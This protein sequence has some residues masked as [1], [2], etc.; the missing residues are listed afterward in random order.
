MARAVP[1][2]KLTTVQR[3]P[4]VRRVA[5]AYSGGLD[6]SLCVALLR[7][8]YGVEEVVPITVDVGQG[9]D[10]LDAAA[11]T[12]AVLGI[13]PRV[14]DARE[15]FARDWLAPAI[16]ANADYL[17]YPVATAMT[18]QLIARLVAEQAVALGCDGLAEGSSGK[19]NDQYRMHNVFTLFAPGLPILVPVRDLDLTRTEE[20]ALCAHFGI[21]VDE[22]IPGGDDKTL[23]CR[24][25]ASGGLG[26]DTPI[27]DA[28]WRWY[29]PPERAPDRP[30]TVTLTFTGGI[31]VAL[32]GTPMALA[33]L[34]DAL[35]VLAG[36]YGIGR[37]DIL[38]DGIMGLKS[39]EVYEAPAATVV[40]RAHRDLEQLTLTKEEVQFK[41][42][43]D[44]AWAALVYHGDWFHPLRA[45]LDAFIGRSQEVVEGEVSLRLYKGS[46]EVV[47]RASRQSLFAPE[48]RSIATGG[49][50]QRLCGPAAQIRGL[51]YQVLAL[52]RAR[53]KA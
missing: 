29:V 24:S 4:R 16:R 30:A 33:D 27:P 3:A 13:T 28:V 50:D 43:I 11:R 46:M 9:A 36:G 2:E 39:R 6:S 53:A 35:N 12:A 23:W 5:L 52:R 37:I 41:R 1:L 22:P 40:L 44:Q 42:G 20:R 15:E 21:P 45:D 51:P 19:G 14:I 10:E 32:N 7:E 17:G 26:L 31:P 38:E 25:I 48:L 18:R 47:A 49:F 34:V 8:V